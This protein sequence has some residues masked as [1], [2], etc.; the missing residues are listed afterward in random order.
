MRSW[1]LFLVVVIIAATPVRSHAQTA[2]P[3]QLSLQSS[4][5]DVQTGQSYDVTIHVDNITDLWLADLEIQ[6]D[7]EH[8]YVFGTKSGSPIHAGPFITPGSTTTVR[9]GV[10]RNKIVYTVSLLAPANP[11]SGSGDIATFK[12]YPLAP[13]TAQITFSKASLL[14]VNFATDAA[15][16]RIG[17][18]STELPFTPILVKFNITGAKVDPPKEA[19]ATPLPTE[20]PTTEA[21]APGTTLEPSATA[22]VNATAGPTAVP[23]P[24]SLVPAPTANDNSSFLIILV[25]LVVIAL[26]GLVVVGVVWSR[27]RRR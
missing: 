19:T 21:V 2:V 8:L 23:T 20:T 27:S 6:Y 4:T 5:T 13:G 14:K 18:G 16:Q 22:L 3:S 24:L 25:I 1:V 15:G 12:I 26:I 11:V 9:N 17:T 7:P 10:E